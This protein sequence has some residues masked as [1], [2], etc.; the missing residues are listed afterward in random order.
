MNKIIE[1]EH[2]RIVKY[3][4]MTQAPIKSLILKMAVPT[5][6]SM[7]VSA[8]YNLVDAYFVGNLSTEATAGVGI[9]FAFQAFIQAA[10]FFFGAGSGNFIS[11]ALG[12]RNDKGAENMAA[13]GFFSSIIVGVVIA[14]LG[15]IFLSPLSKILGATQ[16]VISYSNSYLRFILIATPFMISQMVL[17]NQLRLQGNASLAMIGLISGAVLNIILD[18]IFIFH[19]KMGVSGASLATFISQFISWCLLLWGTERKGNIHIRVKNY[20]PSVK[21]FKEMAGGGTPSFL[22]QAL[23]CVSTIIL[24]W[25]AAKYSMPGDEVSTIA[26]FAIVS[27]VMMFGFALILGLGQGFQ[28]VCGFNWGAGLYKRVKDSYIFSIQI[29]TLIILIMCTLG[30]FFAPQIV[31]FFRDEDPLLIEVGARVMRWQ[32]MAFPTV[33][34]TMPTNM[35]LQNI[36]RTYKATLLAMSRQ[37]IFF[38]PAVIIAPRIYGISGLEA[39]IAIA[40]VCTFLL[41]L[42]FAISILKELNMRTRNSTP[43]NENYYG[44]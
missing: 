12:A 43:N 13:T 33:G 36:N 24:N 6:I 30:Y 41:A 9:S 18:P 7:M 23:G 42:P 15:L 27:R 14:T 8:I 37:G 28:P 2:K 10:G 32:C 40:D 3:E 38:L 34:L 11:R 17:N 26:A 44:S 21:L 1:D 35:L 25:A 19:L 5:I 4:M 20:M 16:D 39:T 29:S 31:A 22:R